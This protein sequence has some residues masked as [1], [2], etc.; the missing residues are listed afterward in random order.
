MSSCTRR[1]TARVTYCFLAS[2]PHH[3]RWGLT[4][5]LISWDVLRENVTRLE[6]LEV[7]GYSYVLS[8]PVQR[9]ELLQVG[10][11]GGGR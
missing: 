5:V 3:H 9:K 4:T 8:R 2:S 6:D 1:P 7:Q 10:G 11:Q